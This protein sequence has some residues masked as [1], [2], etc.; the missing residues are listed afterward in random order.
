MSEKLSKRT[1]PENGSETTLPTNKSL[2]RLKGLSSE[3][4]QNKKTS[5]NGAVSQNLT[6]K[7]VQE[8]P[9][10]LPIPK[11]EDTGKKYLSVIEEAAKKAGVSCKTKS[12]FT[13]P[14]VNRGVKKYQMVRQKCTS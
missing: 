2:K 11:M 6:E 8:L 4:L 13:E 10:D 9:V 3:S 12:I 5:I 1:A 7:T 14:D